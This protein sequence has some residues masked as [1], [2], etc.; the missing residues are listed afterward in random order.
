MRL[1]L[2]EDEA[3]NKFVIVHM[4]LAEATQL[5]AA[6]EVASRSVQDHVDEDGIRGIM[7]RAHADLY[8]ALQ[9]GLNE[10]IP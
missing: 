7:P 6:L 1:R 4:P 10:T 8:N 5:E 3:G 2:D 9:H